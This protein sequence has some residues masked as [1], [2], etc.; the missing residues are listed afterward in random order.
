[1][2]RCLRKVL[3]RFQVSEE[4]LNTVLVTIEA[5]IN[6]RPI[7]QGEDGSGALTP[8]HFLVWKRLTVIPT[9]AEPETNGSLTKEFRM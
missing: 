3:G 4:G 8:A 2:K 6:S 5:A 7:V 1:M 9:G